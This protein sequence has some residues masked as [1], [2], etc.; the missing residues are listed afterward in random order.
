MKVLHTLVEIKPVK[1]LDSCGQYYDQPHPTI[2]INTD[3]EHLVQLSTTVHEY[4][5]A[6]F[7]QVADPDEQLTEEQA[8]RLFELG[9]QD[10]VRQ[11]WELLEALRDSK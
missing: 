4:F 6:L 10:L 1:G 8:A 9:V 3:Y 11:N 5:H 2:E 7:R